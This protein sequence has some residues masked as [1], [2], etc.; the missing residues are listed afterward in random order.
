MNLTTEGLSLLIALIPGFLFMKI[1]TLRTGGSKPD[2]STFLVD[3]LISS[4]FIYATAKSL[5]LSITLSNGYQLLLLLIL[6]IIL[7]IF[8]SIAI[9]KDLISKFLQPGSIRQSVHSSIFPV[10]GI[11]EFEGK[12]HLIKLSDGIE[13]VGVI[14]AYNH[15]THEMLIRD[16]RIVVGHGKLSPES[17]WYYIPS[18]DSI[19]FARTLEEKK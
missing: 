16:G 6:T 15:N 19:L 18:G 5:R 9:N 13:I 11:K 8:W 12:W 2:T 14:R 4:F 17:A 10:M 1:V 3:S 7:G